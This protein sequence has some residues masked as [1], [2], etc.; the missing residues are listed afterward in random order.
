MQER[1]EKFNIG[2]YINLM[3]KRR[4]LSIIPFCL[5]MVVGIYLSITLPR[6]Y[7]A[8]TSVLVRPQQ[9]PRD[10]V[11]SIVTADLEARIRSIS[12]QIL[13]RTNLEKI[14][15]QFNLFS[16]PEQRNIPIEKKVNNLRNQ[17]AVEIQSTEKRQQDHVFSIFFTSPNPEEAMR[18]ANGLATLFIDENLKAREAE[19]VDT[20]EFLD[21]ELRTMRS[22]L[23]EVETRLKE[24]RRQYMGELPEQLES[25]LRILDTLQRQLSEREDRLRDEKNRLDVLNNEIE[26]RK[27]SL[28]AGN[29]LPPESGE[30]LT[31]LQLKNQLASLQAS[32]TDRHPDI[33]RLK[34][35]IADLEAKLSSG[36]L[37]MPAEANTN[38]SPEQLM[39]SKLLGD[40]IRQ[41]SQIRYEINDLEDDIRKL[42][43]QIKIYQRR[44]ERTPKREEELIALNRDYNNIQASYSS[45]LNRKLEAEIAVSMEKKQ[46]G[47][48]FSILDRAYLPREPVSPN[49]RR[50][51]MLAVMAG[52]GFGAG[53]IFLLDY[54]DT[55]VK[56][57]DEF[58]SDLGVAVLA[59]VPK[60]YHKKD[61]RLKRLNQLLTMFSLVA[62][63]CLLAGFAV[64]VFNGVE[65]TMEIVRPYLASLEN[66]ITNAWKAIKLGG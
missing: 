65:P 56:N 60:I 63:V 45:L 20:T 25:N 47:E 2:H 34:S 55:S 49:M 6:I 61:V 12:Q 35:R 18:V 16:G 24:Y 40:Q 14:I 10:Y 64:L 50:L 54:F 43:Y 9:V 48:K 66:I 15:K 5:A 44:I 39:A 38:L 37:K 36:E 52:L 31:L 58:E 8:S 17:I 1:D 51:L 27:E 11:Q 21:D 29:A 7:Q 23:E 28:R 32:Y 46:K 41:Q 53:L 57:P 30:A 26:A 3:F 19:A 4:W 22:R 13:S 33:I 59:T 62:A 42:K